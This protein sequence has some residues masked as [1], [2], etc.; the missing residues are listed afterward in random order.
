MQKNIV[1]FNQKNIV[2]QFMEVSNYKKCIKK[3]KSLGKDTKF[4]LKKENKKMCAKQLK[5]MNL[6]MVVVLIFGITTPVTMI[7]AQIQ[8]VLLASD[9][10]DEKLVTGKQVGNFLIAA[11]EEKTV[12]IDSNEKVADD[13]TIFTKRIKLGGTGNVEYRSIH[14]TVSQ[15]AEVFVYAM[16]SSSSSD[17]ILGLY[18]LSGNLIEEMDAPGGNLNKKTFD[19]VAGDYYL[20][21]TSSGVNVYG[22]SVLTGDA[23]EIV[24]S[25]WETVEHPVITEVTQEENNIKVAFE[26]ETSND[27]ADKAYVK[28]FD[29]NNQEL[30][31]I[32]VGK[33][34]NNEK[35][36]TFSVDTSGLYQFQVMGHRNEET[37]GKESN[38]EEIYY[39]LPLEKTVIEV[40]NTAKKGVLVKWIEVTEAEE[41]EILYREVGGAN[42]VSGGVF[43][44]QE[45]YLTELVE[46]KKYEISVRAIRGNDVTLSDAVIKRVKV[47]DER[48]W[49]FTY[50]GQSVSESRNTMEMIDPDELVFKLNSS[51]IKDDGVTIDG[52]GGK[53]TTFHDGV[54]YYYT[55]VDP[56][57]ENF[58]LSATFTI[59]Y[60]NPTPDGQEGFGLLAMDSLGEYG[61]S[62]VNHYTNSAGVLATKFEEVIEDVKYTGKDV[63]GAR[64][65]TGITPEVLSSGD[66]AIGQNGKNESRAFGY[67]AED[68][69]QTGESYRLT[70]KKTN[71]GY[72]GY[73]EDEEEFI[74]YGVDELLQLDK[75]NIYVGFAVARGCNVTI[76]DV[77]F[78]TSNPKT[79]PVAIEKP[80]EKVKYTK[81]IDSPT[82]SGDEA[83]EFVYVS[84]VPGTL[85]VK[86]QHNQV[87]VDRV[88][89]LASADFV[90]EFTLEE[91]LNPY[92]VTFIPDKDYIPGE[93]QVLD[94]YEPITMI[95]EVT[96]KSFNQEVIHVASNGVADGEGTI[97]SPVDIYTA[98][99]FAQ[100]GQTIELL[101]GVYSMPQSLVI[102]RGINGTAEENIVL[103][104]KAEKRAIL[105]FTNADGG[106][107][108]WG[109]YWHIENI[110]ITNTPGN[111]KGLQVAGHNNVISGVKAYNNGDTGIQISGT[112]A[113]PFEKWPT[114]N[115]IL[116]CTSYDNIDPGQNNADGFAAKITVGE[117]NVFRGCIAYNNLDDGWDL[118]AKIETGPIG[119][120]R[121]EN[122][123]AYNNG[124]LTD[125]TGNGDGNG[126]KL[127]GDGIAVEHILVDSIAYNNNNDGVTSNSNPAVVVKNIISYGNHGKNI[128]LY[129]KGDGERKFVMDNVISMKGGKDDDI[130]EMPELMSQGNYLYFGG[131]TINKSGQKLRD[132][133][134]ESTDITK[135]P[136]RA[137]SGDIEMNGLFKILDEASDDS[138]SVSMD[139]PNVY[140]VLSGDTLSGIALEK[141]GRSQ[142]WRVIYEANK[143]TIKDPNYIYI[144]Q[145]LIIPE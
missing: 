94:S 58:E 54:S 27:G 142:K 128:T 93:N 113:E 120:V 95:H 14:F 78:T 79:D 34:A 39:V 144:G 53:F 132:N 143:E 42:Y 114:N 44:G 63:L 101:E 31:A 15:D 115:L 69:V 66:S 23:E 87:V 97:E 6:I 131:E 135:T 68:F 4:Q 111:T 129:G 123:L 141:Y 121:I 2:L 13:G 18:D 138:T 136:V 100:Q 90:T 21:S 7:Q 122:S 81:K 26:L 71:T 74:L 102:S 28:M 80:A 64:F 77:V 75:D 86:N 8:S 73:V 52:K 25:D 140:R 107:V 17:R 5:V 76:N 112:S 29:E 103:Q 40:F 133:I 51:T 30:K 109:N 92:L 88:D 117:G 104:A 82:T 91:G 134:F 83:Y 3:R 84:D 99:S 33:T 137:L 108:L 106:M 118:F 10:E 145:K 127:G 22:V 49:Q 61:V 110:D 67:E 116:N 105:D 98:T 125:G 130:S 55:V 96:Y 38:I 41:Y 35:S 24:R 62:S 50:F 119:S 16:S 11:T 9:L 70:L 65:V 20:A 36:V 45:G 48:E 89:I 60:I 12:T 85:T 47:E 57:T 59:D 1:L 46:G 124:T 126:F 19:I 72:H 56:T 37:E 32:L 139:E 43:D